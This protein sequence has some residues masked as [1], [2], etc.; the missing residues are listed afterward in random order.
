[1]PGNFLTTNF[2]GRS[3]VGNQPATPNPSMQ[4]Q[5]T[6]KQQLQ[7][8][9]PAAGAVPAGSEVTLPSPDPN[10]NA[11]PTKGKGQDSPL[12]EFTG[13]FKMPVDDKGNPVVPDDPLAKPIVSVDQKALREAV[14]K[15]NFAANLN[16]ELLQKALGGDAQALM[17]AMSQVAQNAVTAS[18]TISANMQEQ[19]FQTHTQRFKEALPGQVRG[20]QI[21]QAAPKN[22]Q[23]SH[24]AVAPV[25]ESIKMVISQTNPHLSPDRVNEIAENY[26][27]TMS[28]SLQGDKTPQ[29]GSGGQGGKPAEID[30]MATM[31][32]PNV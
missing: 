28:N 7:N 5:P 10:N 4:P 24:P 30:W 29:S 25:Y 22:S 16:P 32:L 17:Q 8:P 11:D 26:L 2:F 15:T 12:D 6:G 19:A 14:G 1:M 31:G 21:S 3:N 13:F 27:Q 18:L 20:V 23:L 9:N